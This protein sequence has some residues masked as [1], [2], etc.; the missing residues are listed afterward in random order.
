MIIKENLIEPLEEIFKI[1]DGY[2][3]KAEHSG[4][5]KFAR[6]GLDRMFRGIKKTQRLFPQKA[7]L[8][9]AAPTLKLECLMF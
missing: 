1:A 3:E 8:G 5:S 9:Q 2:F 4:F 7:G 6:I